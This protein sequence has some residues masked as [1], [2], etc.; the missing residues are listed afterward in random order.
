MGPR[1]AAIRV[2]AVLRHL[3]TEGLGTVVMEAFERVERPHMAKTSLTSVGN[4]ADSRRRT[5]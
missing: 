1:R 2:I 3:A 5:V 4:S